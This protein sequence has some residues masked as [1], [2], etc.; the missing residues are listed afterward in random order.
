M[1]TVV[2]GFWQ[3]VASEAV[4]PDPFAVVSCVAD[5]SADDGVLV[6]NAF[7]MRLHGAHGDAELPGN[8]LVRHAVADG[9]E[10]FPFAR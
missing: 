2:R 4:L 5:G 10:D 9:H 7:E 1:L 8:G 3:A 6:P